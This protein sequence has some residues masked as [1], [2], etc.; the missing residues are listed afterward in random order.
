M[1]AAAAVAA[2]VAAAAA[3]DANGTQPKLGLTTNRTVSV[4]YAN[5]YCNVHI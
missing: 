2:A 4:R 5:S 1:H 3:A